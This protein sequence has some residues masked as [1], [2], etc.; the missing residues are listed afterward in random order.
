MGRNRIKSRGGSG[1]FIPW[2]VV[3]YRDTLMWKKVKRPSKKLEMEPSYHHVWVFPQRVEIRISKRCLAR[4]HWSVS[5]NSEEVETT[6]TFTDG[7]MEGKNVVYTHSAV[8]FSLKKEG[9]W[10][11]SAT[12][13]NKEDPMLSP[14]VVHGR[15]NIA[16]FH[17][18]V[19]YKIVKLTDSRR[20]WPGAEGRACG[21]MLVK[22][23][24]VGQSFGMTSSYMRA[25]KHHVCS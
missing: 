1:T 14:K 12:G 22:G 18:R 7:W 24:R 10:I 2:P 6:W 9:N 23:D 21:E 19:L 11:I 17:L 15:T 25:R 16:W 5:R 4:V 20:V 3:T 13:M 8:L